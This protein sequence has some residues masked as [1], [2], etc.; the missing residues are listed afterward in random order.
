MKKFVSLLI[1]ICLLASCMMIFTSCDDNDVFEEFYQKWMSYI[2]DDT[3]L[4]DVVIPGSHDAGTSGMLWLAETQNED[5]EDQLE[6]GIRYLDIRVEKKSNGK[7][8]IFHGPITGG[9]FD[10]VLED[11]KDFIEDN[12]TETLILDF[13][14]FNGDSQNDVATLIE[15]W[16][17]NKAIKNTTNLSDIDFVDSLTMQDCRGKVLIIWGSDTGADNTWAFRRNND[18]STIENAVLD[19]EY[20]GESHKQGSEYLIS[21]AI[22]TYISN[23][24]AKNKG[25]FVLQGQLTAP[26]L[27][28]SPKGQERKHSTNM[29]NYVVSLESNAEVLPYINI[30][31]RDYV[32]T[33]DMGKIDSIL[34]LNIAKGVV[35]TDN[36]TLFDNIT[37]VLV[38]P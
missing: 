10:D 38:N 3:L 18:E 4:K 26:K 24:I 28:N 5:V 8:V 14:H 11:I 25:L 2:K 23:Y 6:A 7:L 13:Q 22:P 29:T 34:H 36:I 15:L 31:M 17:G 30:I 37:K 19:S 33:E 16:L 20:D 1:V 35:K 9:K 21:T 27:L 12:P 32:I